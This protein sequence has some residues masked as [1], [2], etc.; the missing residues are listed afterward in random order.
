MTRF[1]LGLFIIVL[2]LGCCPTQPLPIER[3]PATPLAIIQKSIKG[4]KIVDYKPI[5][6]GDFRLNP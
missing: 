3:R 6:Q 5:T 1:C 2:L 4:D